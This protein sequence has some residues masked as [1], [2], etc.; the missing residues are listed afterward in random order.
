MRSQIT[1]LIELPHQSH[2]LP[3]VGIFFGQAVAGGPIYICPFPGRQHDL[4][5][6][7]IFRIKLNHPNAVQGGEHA[8]FFHGIGI[9]IA[10]D[11]IAEVGPRGIADRLKKGLAHVGTVKEDFNLERPQSGFRG[12][13]EPDDVFHF[14]L[15]GGGEV[16]DPHHIGMQPLVAVGTAAIARALFINP[17]AVHAQFDAQVIG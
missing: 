11:Q 5:V 1:G 3:E 8:Q 16:L 14:R 15:P 10:S 9:N 17:L 13:I 7:G 4:T 12:R 6:G 2:E